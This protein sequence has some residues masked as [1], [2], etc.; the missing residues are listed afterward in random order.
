MVV[1]V[2]GLSG[3]MGLGE[4]LQ[5]YIPHERHEA[6]QVVYLKQLYSLLYIKMVFEC[7]VSQL[8]LILLHFYESYRMV[9][10]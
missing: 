2:I 10:G 6:V 5:L 1:A 3:V 7:M 4:G 8:Y 9:L